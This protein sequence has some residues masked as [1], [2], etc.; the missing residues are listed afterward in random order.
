MTSRRIANQ[1]G[2]LGVA[3]SDAAVA[4]MQEDT[5]LN[6][7][8]AA[9]LITLGP[10]P[11]ESAES[12][13]AV[14]G[15][16]HSATVRVVDRLQ[17]AGLVARRPGSDRRVMLLRLTA[18]GRRLRARLV[19]AREAALT[20]A[21]VRLSPAETRRVDAMLA[22]LLDGLVTSRARAEHIC[23]FC[24]EDACEPDCP[25]ERAEERYERIT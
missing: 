23:R 14:L 3:L 21:L 19:A 13:S 1:L 4:A 22:R 18:K 10:N 7:S 5:G 24:D 20:A 8:D 6:P 17:R 15:L 16:S 11:D 2:A 25:V 12:L 9:A